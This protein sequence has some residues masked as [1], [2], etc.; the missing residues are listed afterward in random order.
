M[1]V[2]TG[3]KRLLKK[4]ISIE[5]D[6]AE[7]YDLWATAYDNQP[8]NLMLDLDR[9]IF[10][11][12][13]GHVTLEGRSV[14][15][16]GCG[17]GRHWEKILGK[18]PSRLTGFDVSP[19]MLDKLKQKFPGAEAILI[20]DD[21]LPT[22][23][24]GTYATIISTLTVAHIKDI[25]TALLAWIRILK[26]DGEIIITD[27]HPQLLAGGGK[28]T[29]SYNDRRVSITNYIH[30]VDK[31]K[32]FFREN[33]FSVVAEEEKVINESVKDYYIKQHALDVYNKF[34]G[35]PV[36]YG[37]HLKRSNGIK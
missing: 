14:A 28:R 9:I 33:G 26:D 12:L 5:K 27:F 24:G 1:S 17:T 21:S 36:I 11:T 3:I 23:P 16:I 4:D 7:A 29:F 25:E 18:K 34:K 2:I 30:P 13:F 31:I 19:G 15:D 22:V 6:S 20:T 35:Y 10:N 8:G 37:L 32:S